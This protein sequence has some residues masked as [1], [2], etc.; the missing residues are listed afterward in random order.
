MKDKFEWVRKKIKDFNENKSEEEV[1]AVVVRWMG[2]DVELGR[3]YEIVEREIRI[4][5]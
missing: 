2:W 3:K 4:K 5:K 1:L